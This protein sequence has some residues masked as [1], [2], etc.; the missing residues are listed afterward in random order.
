MGASRSIGRGRQLLGQGD[1]VRVAKDD[2]GLGGMSIRVGGNFHG[3]RWVMIEW[4][5]LWNL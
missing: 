3:D 4:N 1:V 5:E 2:W